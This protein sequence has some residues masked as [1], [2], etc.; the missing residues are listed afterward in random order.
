[1]VRKH[2]SPFKQEAFFGG[3]FI[4]QMDA[5]LNPG[6]DMSH[7]GCGSNKVGMKDYSDAIQ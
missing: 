1:M 4:W 2:I 3:G 5:I 7:S 6:R